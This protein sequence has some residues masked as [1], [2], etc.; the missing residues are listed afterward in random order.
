LRVD[1]RILA[2]TNRDLERAIAD[3]RFREDLYHRLNVVTIHLP[4]LRER[5]ADIPA[6]ASAFLAR[7]AAELEVERP[8]LPETAL[9]LLCSY[10]WPG[11]VRELEHCLR[12]A[13]I[14]TRGFTIRREDLLL[15][16]DRKPASVG[17][18]GQAN[19]DD[20]LREF[21][22]RHLE[23][24]AGPGCEP[25][26]IETIEKE[27]VLEAL[28]RSNGNQ[29]RAA[30]LLGIPRPTFHAKLQRHRVRT[31]TVVDQKPL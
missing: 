25:D 13:L 15:A 19:H 18:A 6:L 17:S 2:A 16:L 7:F 11:N 29:S 8:T 20:L 10:D 9:E 28:R 3:G 21:L 27:L 22:S 1:A 12:R 4:P 30:E 5:R 23:M 24:H 31:T 26:L 14:F